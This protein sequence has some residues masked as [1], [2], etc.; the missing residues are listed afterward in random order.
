MVGMYERILK[1]KKRKIFHCLQYV[2][3]KV[4]LELE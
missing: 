1:K 2:F 4:R 3:L